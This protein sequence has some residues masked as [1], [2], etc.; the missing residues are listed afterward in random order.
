MQIHPT[1]A[2]VDVA[3]AGVVGLGVGLLSQQAA[4]VAWTGALLVGLAIARSVTQ[5]GIARIR[6]AGFEMLWRS[7]PRVR[8]IA[9]GRKRGTRSRGPKPR[10]AR[11]AL[12]GAA[13]GGFAQL[14]T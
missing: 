13:P 11:R 8:R 3:I 2:A 14:W 7:E 10:Y 6:A 5:V 9:R 1:R 4:I 12:R